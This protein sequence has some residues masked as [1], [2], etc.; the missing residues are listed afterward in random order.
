MSGLRLSPLES[1]MSLLAALCSA[2]H[3][4]AVLR[5]APLSEWSR[6]GELGPAMAWAFITLYWLGWL[7]RRGRTEGES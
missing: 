3:F 6:L 2:G 1:A 4:A 7:P 5:G